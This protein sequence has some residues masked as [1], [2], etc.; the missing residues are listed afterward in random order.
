MRGSEHKLEY[1]KFQ[2]DIEK[3]FYHQSGRMLEQVPRE[4]VAL[5]SL[6]VLDLI[7]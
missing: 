7:S 2:L 1:G 5:S 3:Y 6:D 4:D